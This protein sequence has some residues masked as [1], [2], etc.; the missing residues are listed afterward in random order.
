M[1]LSKSKQYF[2]QNEIKQLDPL[3]F[4]ISINLSTLAKVKFRREDYREG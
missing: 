4:A 3:N 1:N 2:L